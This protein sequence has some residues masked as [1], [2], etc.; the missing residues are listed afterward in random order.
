MEN[1]NELHADES[2]FMPF[3]PIVLIQDVAK[4]WLLILLAA[5]IV[6]IGAYIKTDMEYAPVYQTNTTYVVTTRSSSSTVYSNLSSTSTL[7]SV[8]TELLNSSILRNAILQEIGAKSFNGT[9]NAAVIPETNLVTVQVTA[10]DPRTA[11]LV[12][13]A[14]IDHHETVTYQV[15]DGISLEVLQNPVVPTAPANYANASA[16]MKR[17]MVLTALVVF[18]VLA[19][20]SYL[21]DTVRSGKEARQKLECDYLGEIPHEQKYKTLFSRI[22]HKKTSI[23]ITN[24]ITSF[25]FVETIRKLR[26]RVE[27]HMHGD[28]VLMVTSLLENEGKSTVA[29]NL[30]LAMS[31]KHAKVLLIDCDLRKPACHAL[32]EQKNVPYGLRDVLMGKA[33]LADAMVRDKRSNLFLLLEKRGTKNSGD[34]LASERMQAL[35]RW[36]RKEFDFVVLDLP[37]MAEVSDA[38]SIMELADASLLVVRQNTAVAPAV[39]K[40]IASLDSGKAKLLGCVLNNVSSTSLSSGQG[41]GYGGYGKYGH[42]GHYGHYGAKGSGK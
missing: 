37:P 28:K 34:L 38:E 39:N 6:G 20:A 42:Y 29:V 31:Q 7:A 1:K 33:N 14:I 10:S 8:F 19:I 32:L 12:A 30:A 21:R 2:G 22:R 27:Q 9:I 18:G 4:R 41:Y 36:A 26:R 25:R 35:L 23:L 40:A 16:Q 11:F 13:Q 17:M 5:L 3:D 24:P 15:V